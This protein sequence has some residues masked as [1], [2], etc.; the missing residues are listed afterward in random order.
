V[1]D[2]TY[3][4]APIA[5]DPWANSLNDGL[6]CTKT[7]FKEYG[8]CYDCMDGSFATADGLSCEFPK[9]NFVDEFGNPIDDYIYEDEVLDSVEEVCPANTFLNAD[10]VC[11]PYTS[12]Q[13][14]V[15]SPPLL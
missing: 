10:G 8:M 6:E 2:N 7:Q 5:D 12:S 13:S 14:V 3:P 9:N 1:V 15:V 11:E 4:T